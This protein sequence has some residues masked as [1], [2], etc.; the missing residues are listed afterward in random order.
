MGV[1]GGAAL[2]DRGAGASPELFYRGGRGR[3]VDFVVR[4]G[5]RVA[6]I[7]AKSSAGTGTLPGMD[8]FTQT[9]PPQRTRRVGGDGRPRAAVLSDARGRPC[10][11]RAHPLTQGPLSPADE[12]RA[13]APPSVPALL[14]PDGVQASG[15]AARR[16]A[17]ASVSGEPMSCQ[18]LPSAR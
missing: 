15:P 17:A 11:G 7:P 5:K 2:L 1:G 10:G 18:Y 6:A 9:F 14:L 4:V 13:N 8:A 12:V 16:R 3:E